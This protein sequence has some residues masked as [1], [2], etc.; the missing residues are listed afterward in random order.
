MVAI[1][2]E[3]LSDGTLPPDVGEV[4]WMLD[5]AHL[6]QRGEPPLSITS[7][8]SGTLEVDT[9]GPSHA[10]LQIDL[11]QST[12]G[13]HVQAPGHDR[14]WFET[15]PEERDA[16][17]KRICVDQP[18]PVTLLRTMKC[19]PAAGVGALSPDENLRTWATGRKRVDASTFGTTD[20][21]RMLAWCEANV[22]PDAPLTTPSPSAPA[23][24]LQNGL[25][26]S[27]PVR[28]DLFAD[29]RGWIHLPGERRLCFM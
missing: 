29:Q 4:R 27:K 22:D 15:P 17:E 24:T 11:Y 12:E 8:C 6:P 2:C 28:I 26:P 14:I 9:G 13:G 1:H 7:W 5:G 10:Q 23:V 19:H 18:L 25:D 21:S 16:K 3:S 20:G